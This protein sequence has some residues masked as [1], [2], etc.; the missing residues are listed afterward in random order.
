M[1]KPGDKLFIQ[2][3]AESEERKFRRALVLEGKNN[4]VAATIDDDS[5][6]VARDDE[7]LLFFNRESEFVQQTARVT[8]VEDLGSM[9]LAEFE[10]TSDPISAENRAD[11]RITTITA[12]AQAVLGSGGACP[13]RDASVTGFAVISPAEHSIGSLLDVDFY[14]QDEHFAGRVSVQSCRA[15]SSKL[16]RYGLRCLDLSREGGSLASGLTTLTLEAQRAQLARSG[17][18]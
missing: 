11:F 18:D 15:M 7:V 8:H 3:S 9:L 16:T 14:F 17:K 6:R 13:V 12:N 2:F 4:G 1:L 5:V 10:A